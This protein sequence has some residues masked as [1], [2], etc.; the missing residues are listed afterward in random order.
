VN[1]RSFVIIAENKFNVES[2]LGK[3]NKRARKLGLE[4]V[5]F[6]WGK[7][8]VETREVFTREVDRFVKIEVLV[9]PID[10]TGP[11]DICFDGWKFVATLQ[12]LPTGEN[13]IRCISNEEIPK[14]YRSVGSDCNH[15]NVNRYRKDTYLVRNESTETFVQVGS[16]CIKDFLGGNCPDDI[17]NKANLIA[18]LFSYMEGSNSDYTSGFNNKESLYEI[19]K[20]LAMTSASIRDYGWVSKSKAKARD[21]GTLSTSTLVQQSLEEPSK[22]NSSKIT[23]LDKEIAKNSIEWVENLSD[24][25]CESD[26][27]YNIRAIVRSGM[28][29]NKCFGFA[30]SIIPAYHRMISEKNPV[31]KSNHVGTIKQRSVFDLTFQ[32]H[33]VF[34]SMYGMTYKFVFHDDDGNIITWTTTSVGKIPFIKG[35][36]YSIKGTVKE[37]TEYKNVPQTVLSRCTI[38]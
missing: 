32:D 30:A 27:L 2:Q 36:K 17:I 3:I 38:I 23:D 31:N 4:E 34:D 18:E 19:G 11:F 14:Q 28:V 25:E 35:N 7:A 16:S 29:W 13:I 37:H 6:I 5:S 1:T 12:H 21:T 22:S 9:I 26:Y 20:F 24:L 10:I 33:F 15:C 8:F